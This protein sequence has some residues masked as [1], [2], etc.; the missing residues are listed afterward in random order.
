MKNST[1]LT[2][3]EPS[4]SETLENILA[5]T[6]AKKRGSQWQ[7]RC[8]AHNDRS[9]S[10][11]IR[12]GDNGGILLR[13]H[14]GCTAEAVAD[15]LGLT[16]S[17]LFPDKAGSPLPKIEERNG[18]PSGGTG[19]K[20]RHVCFYDYRDE[21][22]TLLFQT[23]RKE[24]SNPEAW[25]DAKR[26]TFT[27]R[28][29]DGKGGWS[30]S[31]GSVRRV[32]YRLPELTAADPQATVFVCEGE[33]DSDRLRSLGL[34]ATC[35]PMGA[36]K[37]R[38]EYAESLAG[39]EVI[40]LPD[41]D[42]PGR[43]HAQD[44]AKSLHGCA[45]SV[46]VL[47]LPGL[48]EKGDVSDW[49]RAGGDAERLCVLADGVP[50][51]TLGSAE[52]KPGARLRLCLTWRELLN[53]KL[54]RGEQVLYELERGELAIAAAVSNVGK[55]TFLRNLALRLA[56]GKEFTRVVSQG[57]PRRVML[58]DFET[59]LPRLQEDI[60]RMLNACTSE[61]CA[62]IADNLH[63]IS[64]A[65]I[66]DEPLSLSNQ[67]HFSYLQSVMAEKQ[68]DLLIV[69][70]VAAA[71]SYRDENSNGEVSNHVCKPLLRLARETNAAIIA[72]HHIGKAKTEEGKASER[73]H[74]MRGAS[75]FSGF[76]SLILNLTQDPHDY[77]RVTLELA[78]VKGA[79]FDDLSL[80]LDPETR[81]FT[82]LYTE[83]AK[84]KTHY[85]RVLELFTEARPILKASDAESLLSGV[86]P[87][88]TVRNCLGQAYANSDLE[89]VK[90]GIYRLPQ[91]RLQAA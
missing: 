46:R 36:G 70:T 78:K 15:A 47:L 11:S 62:A 19:P 91:A 42:E 39:R 25:P 32:L 29:P 43:R 84:P 80:Q 87:A 50:E 69:D 31:L 6:S 10:L 12:L 34:V 5:Q 86:I 7:A 71:F 55:S 8:P 73:I 48:P 65:F 18:G 23:E 14:A 74:R 59:R 4:I 44:V 9:P 17:E 20:Y 61:E 35:N 30:Y 33:A 13:C 75:A 85:E 76:A 28:R 58:L 79:R 57:T 81:W 89:H 66:G 56:S 63:I 26:K 21:A 90:R 41:N 51:W 40:I 82:S 45:A 37:W 38:A 67:T 52:Q 49:L 1:S 88:K 72:A 60:R 3:F 22:G 2:A 83:P 16:F 64:D 54:Q 27:Q 68:I 77:N 53:L 24:L